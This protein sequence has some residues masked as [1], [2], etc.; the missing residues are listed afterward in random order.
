MKTTLTIKKETYQKLIELKMKYS[1][2]ERKPL[3][4]DEFF[5]DLV[6]R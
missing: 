2:R 6:E 1:L 5:L 3:T 4:W